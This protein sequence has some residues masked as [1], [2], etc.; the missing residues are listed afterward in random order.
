VE[1]ESTTGAAILDIAHGT[2]SH[3]SIKYDWTVVMMK[4]VEEDAGIGKL[5]L[6]GVIVCEVR[7]RV[8]R[9]QGIIEPSGLPIPGLHRIEGA[10]EFEAS[11]DA[12]EWVG[13]PMH[14]K[15]QDGRL[16]GIT[17]ASDGRI[18]GEGHGPSKCLCC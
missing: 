7:Y 2:S 5:L 8:R 10:V 18:F 14:L 4:L 12:Q 6:N 3:R 11:T 17:L 16:L 1:G 15:F 13:T 9:Y